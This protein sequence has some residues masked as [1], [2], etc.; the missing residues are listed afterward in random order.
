MR[1]LVLLPILRD[2]A[3]E[4]ETKK[5]LA[6]IA[7]STTQYEVRSLPSGPASIESEYDEWV[8]SPYILNEIVRAEKEGFDAVFV[9]CILDVATNAAR[10]MVKIPV[11]AAYR[12]CAAVALTLGDKFGV[13][14]IVDSVVPILF[15]KTREY[16]LVENLAGIRSIEVPVLELDAHREKVLESMVRESRILIDENK[17]DSIILGCTGLVGMAQLLQE[18]IKVPVLDPTPICTKFVELLLTAGVSQSSHAYYKPPEK[19]RR[20][21]NVPYLTG[22]S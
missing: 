4:R 20:L 19:F 22:D 6:R 11:I 15:R 21:S 2:D 10:E 1:I 9:S 14:T 7:S 5:E 18:K 3:I 13:V 12:T 17:A 16:G 8:T